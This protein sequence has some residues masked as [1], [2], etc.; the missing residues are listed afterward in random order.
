MPEKDPRLRTSVREN[1]QT[2]VRRVLLQVLGLN[3]TVV[4]GK[5]VIGWK[6]RSLSI[7]SDAA[8]SSVDSLNNIVGLIII[9]YATAAPDTGHPY[10]HRK[11]ESLAAFALGGLLLFTCF[12][13]A[14][15]AIRRLFNPEMI[16]V[17]VSHLTLVV[18][19]A[20][21]VINV[22]VYLYER[23]RGRQLGSSFLLADSLH[24]RTDILVSS[25]LVGGLFF[26]RLGMPTLDPLFALAISG[27]IAYGGWQI[28]TESVPVLVDA[29]MV[30][31]EIIEEIVRQV[32]GVSSVH[33]IRSRSDGEKLFIE[34]RVLVDHYDLRRAHQVTEEIE[35]RLMDKLGHCQI[36]IHVEPV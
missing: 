6:A 3:L 15:S 24:T 36:T 26:I 30:R 31:P 27:L 35:H 17:Q 21:I 1:Y 19:I 32:P 20:T 2:Q 22:I 11:I 25:S 9:R 34:L 18:M 23:Q 14:A 12:E 13:I 5:L 8:H 7:L 29:S 4:V 10:G 33:D 28:F 16:R